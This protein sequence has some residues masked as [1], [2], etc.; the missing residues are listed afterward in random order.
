MAISLRF[1]RLPVAAALAF[2]ALP[3]AATQI[4]LQAGRSY[5]DNHAANTVFVESV[6]DEHPL[7]N[8]SLHWAPDVSLGWIDGRD[9]GRYQHARYGTRGAIWLAAGG[10][11]LNAGSSSDWYHHFF[12]SFQV[13]LHSGRTQALSSAYEFVNS[14]GWQWHHFSFEIRHISN[15]KL[16]EPN[17]GETMALVGV[18]FDIQ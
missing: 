14:V 6:F 15:G 11:R 5:M 10:V 13:A 7:G 17:R 9:I 16:H 2:A 12:Y 1:L 3:A 4:E 18:G 8:T